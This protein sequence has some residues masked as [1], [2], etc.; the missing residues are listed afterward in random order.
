MLQLSASKFKKNEN[1]IYQFRS[2]SY[3]NY[4]S[5]PAAPTT[6]QNNYNPQPQPSGESSYDKLVFFNFHNPK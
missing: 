4:D 3:D 2:S 6:S 1:N 5:Q